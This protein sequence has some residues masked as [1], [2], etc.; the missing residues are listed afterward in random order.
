MLALCIVQCTTRAQIIKES[1][2]AVLRRRVQ[3]Y[4]SLKI[5]GDL[6]KS[7]GYEIPSYREKVN[8]VD[9]IR[10]QG[11]ILRWTEAEI[12]EIEVDGT[13]RARIDGFVRF[14]YQIPQFRIDKGESTV[15]EIWA[16]E[17]GEWYHVPSGFVYQ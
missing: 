8:V 7:Y 12:R 2:E 1:D 3:E 6:D 16:K 4:W 11:Q 5:K 9:Y 13:D 14:R 10:S 17:K 15:S